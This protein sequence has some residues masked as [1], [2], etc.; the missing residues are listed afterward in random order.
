MHTILEHI[1]KAA[2]AI[3]AALWGIIH[4]TIP[5]IGACLLAAVADVI[6]AYRL[7]RRIARQG[8][9]AEGKFSSSKA[10]AMFGTLL[11]VYLVMLALAAL[12]AW[13]LRDADIMLPNG[14][15]TVFCF[16]EVVSVLENESSSNGHPWAKV[17]QRFLKDKTSR[18]ITIIHDLSDAPKE[19]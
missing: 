12:Q 4:P 19:Q 1:T 17:A 6:S 10:M 8:M 9:P 16:V 11:M 2:L 5:F 14:V 18:H 13:V 3:V 15:A 7:D